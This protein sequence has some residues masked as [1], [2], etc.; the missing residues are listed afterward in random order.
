MSNCGKRI[1]LNRVFG[2]P[3]RKALVVA[4]D[5][6]LVLGPIPGTTDPSAQIRRFAE[7]GAD[8]IMMNFGI[9]ERCVDSLLT[10]HSPAIIL[11]LDWTS[12]WSA[13]GDSK[14]ISQLLATPEQGL[15][16]G[17]D[18]VLTFLVIGTGDAEFESREV[19]RNAEVARECERLGIPLIVESLARGKRV[20]NPTALEWM[21][22]HTRIASELGADVIKT[23]YTG[24]PATMR[25][26]VGG[27]PAPV[28]V[29]GG[30]RRASDED[31]L[32]VVHGAVQAGAAG[33][34]FGRNVFQA[35]DLP[36]FLGRTRA[37]LDG[38]EQQELAVA[39]A[40]E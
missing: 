29:L 3:N 7:C 38:H 37:I 2:G 18:A 14:L 16:C 13:D 4:F 21:K 33:V 11:R 22:L 36:E 1:R 25:E 12:V 30:A 9:L 27:S 10:E 34:F 17:A 32:H 35:A 28:L 20:T 19:L 8:A 6:G 31:A 26:V 15:R 5:H 24:D 39:R 23:E 40:T